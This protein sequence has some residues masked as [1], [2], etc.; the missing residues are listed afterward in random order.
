M[1][2]VVHALVVGL[3]VSAI[4]VG[5]LWGAI[6]LS[7]WMTATIGALAGFLTSVFFIIFAIIFCATWKVN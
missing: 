5:F 7:M 3:G 1:N 6:S 2:K 4:V